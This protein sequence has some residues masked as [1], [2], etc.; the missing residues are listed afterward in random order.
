LTNIA[1]GFI[2]AVSLGVDKAH[3]GETI[4]ANDIKLNN[5]NI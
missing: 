1:T 3:T 4:R 2:E 5:L